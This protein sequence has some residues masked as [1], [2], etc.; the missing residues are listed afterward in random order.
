VQEFGHL[1]GRSNKME[2]AA[3]ATESPTDNRAR[4]EWVIQAESGARIEIKIKSERAGSLNKEVIL[5]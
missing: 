2:V 5:P 1:E 4:L 3:H